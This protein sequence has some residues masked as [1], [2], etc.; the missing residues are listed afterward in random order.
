MSKKEQGAKIGRGNKGLSV[1]TKFHLLDIEQGSITPTTHKVRDL[2]KDINDMAQ[3][4]NVSDLVTDGNV[5]DKMDDAIFYRET[6]HHDTW[7]SPIL[8]FGIN[9]YPT[10]IKT[11]LA[12]HNKNQQE[13]LKQAEL[14][15]MSNASNSTNY[16]KFV[17]QVILTQLEQD[18]MQH[19]V[20]Y[21]T[22][23]KLKVVLIDIFPRALKA[24]KSI[25]L[26]D[27]EIPVSIDKP[28]P[29]HTVV[30]YSNSEKG[31]ILVLDPNNP[32]FSGHLKHSNKAVITDDN[33]SDTH[34]IYAPKAGV[35]TGPNKDQYRDCIDL[36]A[37]LAALLDMDTTNYTNHDD[38]IKSEVVKVV[39]NNLAITKLEVDNPLRIKQVSHLKK[40][41]EISQALQQLNDKAKIEAEKA[42][43]IRKAEEQAAKD[44]YNSQIIEI[45]NDLESNISELIGKVA[46]DSDLSGGHYA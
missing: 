11:Y 3:Y 19:A 23:N 29:T 38:I 16:P 36:A 45:N 34:K 1:D 44:K 24:E 27:I 30:L 17:T 22:V 10:P 32:R 46:E 6:Y 2:F 39:S 28:I 8:R 42:L 4:I 43:Q 15:K 20:Q 18:L 13:A 21:L 41:S 14:D 25:K 7:K 31:Q 35:T 37:K 40:M 5:P 33:Q 9:G 26:G 12:D